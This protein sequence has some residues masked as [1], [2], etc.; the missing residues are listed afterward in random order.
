MV[1]SKPSTSG[2]PTPNALLER[3]HQFKGDLVRTYNITKIYVEK[4]DLWTG[5]L[6]LALF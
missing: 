6:D 4:Y 3:I 1:P 2:N 5:I